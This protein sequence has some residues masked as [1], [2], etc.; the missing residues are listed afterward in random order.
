MDKHLEDI[1]LEAAV[2]SVLTIENLRSRSTVTHDN[3]T[4][5]AWR[6]YEEGDVSSLRTEVSSAIRA[7]EE[8]ASLTAG[9]EQGEV[10][11]PVNEE[12][13]GCAL[14]AFIEARNRFTFKRLSDEGIQLV[15]ERALRCDQSENRACVLSA[16]LAYS[17]VASGEY[18]RILAEG[19]EV[20]TVE[21]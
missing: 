16:V 3:A 18:E 20:V 14:Y 6:F 7:Y 19:Q 21:A 13:L 17:A 4:E 2:L 8:V 15:C 11:V 1:A 5:L 10:Q 12:A 9:S